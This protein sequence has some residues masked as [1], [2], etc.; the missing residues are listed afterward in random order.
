M[1]IT[2]VSTFVHV[3]LMSSHKFELIMVGV[4][5]QVPHNGVL[6]AL[7]QVQVEILVVTQCG[8]PVA[9]WHVSYDE[10]LTGETCDSVKGYTFCFNTANV[11]CSDITG[12]TTHITVYTCRYTGYSYSQMATR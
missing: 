3:Y 8:P 6:M 10:D 2:T 7:G 4:S 5:K 12:M 9:G 1:R 11:T